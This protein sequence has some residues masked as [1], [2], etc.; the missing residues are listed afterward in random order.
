MF[1]GRDS[2][3]ILIGVLLYI[4]TISNFL[5]S[6]FIKHLTYFMNGET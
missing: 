4:L 1:Y 3:H 6:N 2:S 5:N